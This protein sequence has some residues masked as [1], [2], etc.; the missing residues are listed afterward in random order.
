MKRALFIEA[1]VLIA[2]AV[3][4]WPAAAQM[5][6]MAEPACPAGAEPI[7]AEFAH[8][9]HRAQL[10]AA[11]DAATLAKARL[12]PGKAVDLAL[13]PTPDVR[14]SLRP[15]RPGGSVSHGG[16]AMFTVSATGT[17][18]VAIGSGAWLD[19]VHDGAAATS[20]GHGHGPACSGIRKMVD[21]KLEPGD[22]VLQIVGNG[23]PAIPVMVVRL[24]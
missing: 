19:I 24:P 14:Y 21:F 18:R 5:A 20:V 16:M 2:L 13:R 15:E 9:A 22:Y 11:V 4:S 1:A 12:E 6:P 10:P 8:W 7:P 23:T 17:Y 3:P